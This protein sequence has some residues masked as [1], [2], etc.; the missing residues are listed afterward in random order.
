MNKQNAF[1]LFLAALV[2]FFIL[3]VGVLIAEGQGIAA[4]LSFLASFV[5]MGFGFRLKKKW[6]TQADQ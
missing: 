5:L 2:V 1:F 4:T 3:L 6:N